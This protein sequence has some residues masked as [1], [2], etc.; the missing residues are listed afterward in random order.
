MNGKLKA[1]IWILALVVL[2]G[3][4]YFVYDYLNDKVGD[5]GNLAAPSAAPSV[6]PS[7]TPS[8]SAAPTVPPAAPE[9]AATSAEN[10]A[11][12]S[13]AETQD[14]TDTAGHAEEPEET[15]DARIPAPDFTVINTNGD[16]V[17]LS[18]FLGTPVVLNFWASWCPP[19]KSEMPEFDKVYKDPGADVAF[20]MVDLVDGQR[21]T[22]E[23]GA[24]HIEEQGYAFPVFYDVSGE[25]GYSYGISSI[26]TTVFI[27]K[28]G[29]IVTGAIGA[30]NEQTLRTGIGYITTPR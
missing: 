8:A 7:G 6:M 15:E 1:G 27:D 21:E 14:K 25:A 20:L 30:L 24:R 3:A 17:K 11:A 2:I 5:A 4:A 29:Y 18:D 28:D 22:V 12:A 9:S 10:A 23:S 16:E 19:C 13:P 26:P